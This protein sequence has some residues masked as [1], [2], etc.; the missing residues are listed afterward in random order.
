MLNAGLVEKSGALVP[1]LLKN[2]AMGQACTR[3]KSVSVLVLSIYVGQA[4][5]K[6]MFSDA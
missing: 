3:R 1:S 2:S 6:S 4:Y 5:K